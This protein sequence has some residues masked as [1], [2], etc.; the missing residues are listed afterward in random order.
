MNEI[1]KYFPDLSQEQ[2]QLFERLGPLFLEWNEKVNLISRKDTDQFYER[3]VLHSLAIAKVFQFEPSSRIMDLGCGGGFP[4]IPLAILRPDCNFLMVDSIRKKINVVSDL[5]EQLELP[6]A[7]TQ[8]KRAEE[9]DGKFDIV[10]T[11]AVA[12]TEKLLRWTRR[13]TKHVIAL[14][15]GDLDQE[16]RN[17]SNIKKK[18]NIHPIKDF[19]EEEFFETKVV[20]D[21]RL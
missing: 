10:V 13:K 4:G 18:L 6:N 9:V 12:Q 5:I 7:A 11:R 14:K 17:V 1:L 3:H 8:W 2:I 15:G 16:I 21:I 19:F 20:M